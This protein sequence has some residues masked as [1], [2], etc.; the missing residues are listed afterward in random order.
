[1]FIQKIGRQSVCKCI[2]S[3]TLENIEVE[4]TPGVTR[5]LPAEGIK[6]ANIYA[7]YWCFTEKNGCYAILNMYFG[8]FLKLKKVYIRDKEEIQSECTILIVNS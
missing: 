6:L 7:V 5:I 8:T 4:K 1:M 2:I 3:F